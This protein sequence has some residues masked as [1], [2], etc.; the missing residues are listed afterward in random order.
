MT[1][2]AG[3]DRALPPGPLGDEFEACWC[4]GRLRARPPLF[5]LL[6]HSLKSPLHSFEVVLDLLQL[7]PGEPSFQ[8]CVPLIQQ[9]TKVKED[10]LTILNEG[11]PC[12]E[13]VAAQLCRL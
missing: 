12:V 11:R 8:S 6:F 5:H 1:S 7:V 9:L 4:G 13:Q 2:L 3:K 10:T